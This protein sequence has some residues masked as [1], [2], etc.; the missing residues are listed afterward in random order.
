MS[1]TRY[2]IRSTQDGRWLAIGY[3]GSEPIALWTDASRCWT[4]ESYS[5][6]AM[7]ALRLLDDLT[8]SQW[9]VEPILSTD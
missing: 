7:I 5:H 3:A 6:A 9:A 2:A 1:T 8:C 4:W